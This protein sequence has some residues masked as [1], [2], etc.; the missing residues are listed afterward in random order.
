MEKKMKKQNKQRRG[1]WGIVMTAVVL[2]GLSVNWVQAQDIKINTRPLTP[3]EIVDNGLDA[4]TQTANGTHVVGLGQPV[5][6]ELL[7]EA[8]TVVTQAVWTLDSVV[9]GS[10]ATLTDSPIPM[11]MA[12][13]DAG[14]QNDFDVIDRA[15]IVPDLQG[16]YEIS[17]QAFITNA[18]LTASKSV[19]ASMFF[20]ERN[21]ATSGPDTICMVCH[22]DK[23]GAIDETA[24]ASSLVTKITG[25]DSPYFAE[26]CIQ[27]HA[28][29]YDPTPGAVNGGFDDIADEFGWT[30]PTEWST[31]NWTDMPAPLQAKSNIQCEN[32]HG[33]ADAHIQSFGD[34]DLV[35]ISLSSGNCG[36]CHDTLTH[37]PENVEWADTLHAK[38][39]VFRDSGSCAACHSTT[40]FLAAHDP[41]YADRDTPGTG[42]EG[43]SCAACHDPHAPGSGA[44]Q[45]RV[46]ESVELGNGAL[47]TDGGDGLICMSCHKSRRDAEEYVHGNASPYFGPHHGP[48]GDMLAGENAIQYGQE[49]PSS[50]HLT[51]VENSCSECHMQDT[52]HESPEYAEHK[53]GGHSFMLSFNDGTNDVIHLTQAC[54]DCHGE[55]EDFD[56]GG[57]DYNRDGMIEGVQ[58]EIHHLLNE[59][60]M[61]LPPYGSPD[62]AVGSAL[63][64][65]ELKRGA[66]NFLFVEED[67]SLGVHN[68]KYAA[69]ILR[70]SID[71]L[72]GG[73]DVD[74]DG[75][76]DSWEIEN[77]G[78]LTSQSGTDDWDGDGL[79]NMAESKLGTSALL[80]D[81]DE[82][83]FSD[84]VE[85]Q[86]NSDPLN[87]DSVPG[88]DM[89]I[90]PA[91]ELGY[92]PKGTGTTVNIQMAS[93][94][95]DGEWT[96][97]GEAQES[98]GNWIYQLD[99]QRG[100]TNRFYRAIE[101]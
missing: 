50:T 4:Y 20:D 67:G 26:Y 77:F 99:S 1:A 30:F 33:P 37:H 19:V 48:Q 3:Q 82:D 38:G 86:G 55:L 17:V 94:L 23:K 29:G 61:L 2:L 73:I 14:D 83:G 70:S 93:D 25:E 91:T 40:G 95:T 52:G 24:H 89:V 56:F 65:L 27:C 28:V 85:L 97:V 10:T 21:Y 60:G 100:T 71:D 41:D 62:V 12:T 63:N 88:S 5:Y 45:V 32:C 80:T 87:I 8:G 54:A 15:L 84:L 68:P 44:H 9:S 43:I 6:L 42:A 35:G 57:A 96:N 49:M 78:N 72:T 64:T 92:M 18:I 51:T 7:V 36:S 13:Y 75:L 39:Y 34:T 79:N 46:I 11:S 81:T 59:L 66:Y 101:E 90:L 31:N 98:D 47:I 74:R 16:V 22:A 53:V 69:A 58:T 76:V